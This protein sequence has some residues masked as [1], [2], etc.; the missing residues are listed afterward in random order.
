MDG[1]MDGQLTGF[2]AILPHPFGSVDCDSQVALF[3]SRLLWKTRFLIKIT[4]RKLT[5][6]EPESCATN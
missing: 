3:R 6:N 2:K 4:F 1:R 5:A